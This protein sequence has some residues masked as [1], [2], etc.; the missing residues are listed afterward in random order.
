MH[1][2]NIL[3]VNKT[4]VLNN[5][6]TK[7]FEQGLNEFQSFEPKENIFH[8]QKDDD[9]LGLSIED[10]KFLKMIGNGFIKNSSENWSAPL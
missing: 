9:P 2:Q 8:R 4:F 5:G 6:R 7:L 10:K 3:T 1:K